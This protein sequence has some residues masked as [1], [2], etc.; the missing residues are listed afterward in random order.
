MET[1]KAALK[2]TIPIATLITPEVPLFTSH[3]KQ[4][5]LA[6]IGDINDG[7]LYTIHNILVTE[8][9]QK[10]VDP[11][12][13]RSEH[14]LVVEQDDQFIQDEQSSDSSEFDGFE[15]KPIDNWVLVIYSIGITEFKHEYIF[16]RIPKIYEKV[17]NFLNQRGYVCGDNKNIVYL[18]LSE[19]S[20]VDCD[21]INTA[22][23]EGQKYLRNYKYIGAYEALTATD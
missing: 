9:G 6:N 8:F 16:G 22:F 19:D 13:C 23:L 2:N 17:H 11:R 12:I 3:T 4:F 15:V 14:N 18:G 21:R 7:D 10:N 20:E 5:I 1:L